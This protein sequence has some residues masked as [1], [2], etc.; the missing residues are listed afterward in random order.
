MCEVQKIRYI[1]N[2]AHSQYPQQL[3]VG[4][5]CAGYMEENLDAAR[6]R[7]ANLKS[8]TR[9]AARAERDRAAQEQWRRQVE[10][11]RRRQAEEQRRRQEATPTERVAELLSGLHRQTTTLKDSIG[12]WRKANP[13]LCPILTGLQRASD[14][15]TLTPWER[16]FTNSVTERYVRDSEL[17]IKQIAQAQ[18]IVRKAIRHFTSNQ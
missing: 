1:H 2:M 8:S 14:C 3:V 4:C 5:I 16:E 6:R 11:Q 10:E 7:E 15:P 18:V 9:R 12:A 17:N 13:R